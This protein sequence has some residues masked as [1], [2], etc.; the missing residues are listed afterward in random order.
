[1]V[2]MIRFRDVGGAVPY[3]F[4]PIFTSSADTSTTLNFVYLK[5]KAAVVDSEV[6]HIDKHPIQ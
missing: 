6:F 2:H 3:G 1:M 5:A 4:K